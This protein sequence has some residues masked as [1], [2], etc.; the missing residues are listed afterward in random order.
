MDNFHQVHLLDE[1]DYLIETRIDVPAIIAH[2]TDTD[3]GPLP[4]VIVTHL[5][6][7]HVEPIP[8]TVHQ[9][10]E[11]MAL[12]LQRVIF[13]NP[14]VQLTDPNHHRFTPLDPSPPALDGRK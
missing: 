8:H 2:R 14:N 1:V 5:R 7:G 6:D 12:A 9:L 11:H 4:K 13:W 10:S 3:L